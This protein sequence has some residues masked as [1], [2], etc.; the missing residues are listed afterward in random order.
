MR[1]VHRDDVSLTDW[2]IYFWFEKTASSVA[3]AELSYVGICGV[4]V[5]SELTDVTAVA[6]LLS[7]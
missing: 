6:D 5:N 7:C 4:A 3:A 2:W 1:N